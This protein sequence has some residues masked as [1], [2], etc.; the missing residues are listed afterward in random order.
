MGGKELRAR[1]G[2][3]GENGRRGGNGYDRGCV[4]SV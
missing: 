4:E 2:V 1:Y 3:G